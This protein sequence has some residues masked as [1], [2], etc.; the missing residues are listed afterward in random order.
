MKPEFSN[1]KSIYLQIAESIQ[2]DILQNV[3]EEET[4]VPSTNQMAIM[5]RINPATAA[6]GINILVNEGILYK[7]RGI[8]MFVSSGAVGKI[9]EKR[10]S[11][12]YDRFVIPLLDEAKRLEISKDELGMMICNSKEN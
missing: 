5:Y 9:R 7:K 10:K 4:Q 11:A 6:K 12:F 2:D 1:E 3:I 8:G